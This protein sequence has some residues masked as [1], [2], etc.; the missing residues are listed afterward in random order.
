M[1]R[2]QGLSPM[3][4]DDASTIQ[5]PITGN[6]TLRATMICTTSWALDMLRS[7]IS[8]AILASSSTRRWYIDLSERIYHENRASALGW[9]SVSSLP[10][11]ASIA[12]HGITE[13]LLRARAIETQ[14][15]VLAPAQIG[16][17]FTGRSSYGKAMIIDPWGTVVAQCND[18]P[19]SSFSSEGRFCLAEYVLP[20][21][22]F[23]NIL[24]LPVWRF[25]RVGSI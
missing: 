4:S 3:E 5:R 24:N 9:V 13:T 6:G 1:V 10:I 22:H 19:A 15:Y 7:T 23:E 18:D 11:Y 8:R 17:H 14:S 25:G 12:N 21:C 20:D 2:N 16:E